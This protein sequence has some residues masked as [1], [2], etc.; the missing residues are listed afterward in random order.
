MIKLFISIYST[1]SSIVLNTWIASVRN[2]YSNAFKT[3][4]QG[5]TSI[6]TPSFVLVD[7]YTSENRFAKLSEKILICSKLK[8]MLGFPVKTFAL[9]SLM[10]LL[11]YF[12]Y[13]YNRGLI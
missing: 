8:I 2:T 3:S 7:L 5:L 4:S 1:A 9:T 10:I 11:T 13:T 6:N 12:S